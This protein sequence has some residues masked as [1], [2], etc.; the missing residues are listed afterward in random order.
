MNMGSPREYVQQ[1]HSWY[2]FFRW[3]VVAAFAWMAVVR[4]TTIHGFAKETSRFWEIAML[5]AAIAFSGYAL[6]ILAIRL[7]L[8]HE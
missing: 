7:N 5:V 4:K 2:A 1:M 8:I 6:L 3:A